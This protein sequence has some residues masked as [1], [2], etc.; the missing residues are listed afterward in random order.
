MCSIKNINLKKKKKMFEF[1]TNQSGFKPGDSCIN[2]SWA[3]VVSRVPKNL[4]M[5]R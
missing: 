1:F 5:N 2:S 4:Y 3:N